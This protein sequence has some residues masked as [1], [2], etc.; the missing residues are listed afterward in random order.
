MKL[1]HFYSSFWIEESLKENQGSGFDVSCVLV[2]KT[3]ID[4]GDSAFGEF[5]FKNVIQGYGSVA[6]QC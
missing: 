6:I 3:Q 4:D 1:C 5:R 2:R